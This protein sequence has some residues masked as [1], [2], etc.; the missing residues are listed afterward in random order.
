MLNELKKNRKPSIFASVQITLCRKVFVSLNQI[1]MALLTN[2]CVFQ[3]FQIWYIYIYIYVYVYIYIY[4]YVYV[5]IYIYIYHRTK[6]VAWF[7]I[8]QC[9][10]DK[11]VEPLKLLFFCNI[12]VGYRDESVVRV[13]QN[14]S[15]FSSKTS[16]FKHIKAVYWLCI[17]RVQLNNF[18]F[19][20]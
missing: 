9:Y 4:I 18:Q 3:V 2:V 17:I 20:C 8:R 5:Y 11:L 15:M 16:R 13:R 12:A 14:W 1:W 6:C 7:C 19:L 10:P